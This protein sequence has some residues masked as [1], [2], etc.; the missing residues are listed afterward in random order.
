M[1]DFGQI[2]R[3]DVAANVYNLKKP[4]LS[5]LWCAGLSFAKVTSTVTKAPRNKKHGLLSSRSTGYDAVSFVLTFRQRSRMM[6]AMF[7]CTCRAVPCH[8]QCHAEKTV[9]NDPFLPQI[10]DGEE[11]SRALRYRYLLVQVSV[12]GTIVKGSSRIP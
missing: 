12:W 5:N 11:Y 3:N 4:K 9:P 1:V 7:M 2:P 6:V 10:F 8:V